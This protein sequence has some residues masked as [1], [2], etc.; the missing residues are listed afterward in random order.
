MIKNFRE[1]WGLNYDDA[2]ES[3]TTTQDS[4]TAENL[5]F[6]AYSQ[7]KKPHCVWFF[8]LHSVF[9]RVVADFGLAT[10]S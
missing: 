10:K 9:I 6:S 7:R 3:A 1:V 5:R 4:Y 2:I 8:P